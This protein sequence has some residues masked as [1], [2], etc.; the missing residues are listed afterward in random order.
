MTSNQLC[1][2]SSGPMLVGSSSSSDDEA[3]IAVEVGGV[4]LRD[5][6]DEEAEDDAAAAAAAA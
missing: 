6:A 3:R 4:K 5:G 1:A 2:V